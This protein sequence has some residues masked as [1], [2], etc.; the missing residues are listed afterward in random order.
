M[1]RVWV[2]E[3]VFFVF[4]SFFFLG[5]MSMSIQASGCEVKMNWGMGMES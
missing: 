4:L 1:K 5:M 3:Q 2:F